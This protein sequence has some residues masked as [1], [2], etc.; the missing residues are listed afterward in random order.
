M[1]YINTLTIQPQA[2]VADV[3]AAM[4]QALSDALGWELKENN[5]VIK[6]GTPMRFCFSTSGGYITVGVNNGVALCSTVTVQFRTTA[7]YCI[8]YISTNSTVALGVRYSEEPAKLV[9]IIAENAQGVSKC[10]SAYS[11]STAYYQSPD[12]NGKYGM[13]LDHTHD[14]RCSTSVVLCP[15]VYG[16]CMFK[17]LYIELSCPYGNTD[18]VYF[19]GGKY[20]RYVGTGSGGFAVPVG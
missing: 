5:D 20:Y 15:D 12:I 4:A 11:S 17:D 19:I 6:P 13:G 16:G 1:A 7:P 3:A 14:S 18:R 8:D 2:S 9:H 10:L